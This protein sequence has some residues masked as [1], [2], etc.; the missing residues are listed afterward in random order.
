MTTSNRREKDAYHPRVSASV[1]GDALWGPRTS[2]CALIRMIGGARADYT[3]PTTGLG[4]T[5]RH[6]P[7]TPRHKTAMKSARWTEITP[8]EYAWEREGPR[9]HQGPP[10]RQRAVSRLVELRVHRRGRQHQRSRSARHIAPQGVPGRDQELEW[11][12]LGR[13]EHLAPRGR[14]QGISCRQSAPAGEPES[15]EA[16][17][18]AEDAEGARQATQTVCRSRRLPVSRWGTVSARRPGSDR[19]VSLR[20]VR[21][22]QS[23]EHPRP[24]WRQC[25]V[26]PAPAAATD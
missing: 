9:L 11:R 3:V 6:G 21:A 4:Q 12:D 16:D 5:R 1:G 26:R 23:S 8:S 10:P 20:R 22:G 25:G 2:E 17:R 14:R 15:E 24:P 19:G 7:P 18:S 13:P